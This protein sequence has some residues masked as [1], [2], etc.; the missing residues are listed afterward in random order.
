MGILKH[1]KQHTELYVLCSSLIALAYQILATSLQVNYTVSHF[2]GD[3][4][5][6]PH[7]TK[8]FTQ[9]HWDEAQRLI[10]QPRST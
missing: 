2:Q 9:F 5:R 10:F 1:R 7:R 3:D 6:E 4:D 8:A